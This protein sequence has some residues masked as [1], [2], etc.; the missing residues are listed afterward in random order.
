MVAV[1]KT[2]APSNM[3][4]L[5]GGAAT[6]E[7]INSEV[8]GLWQYVQVPLSN[9]AGTANAITADCD[10]ALDANKK[11]QKFSLTPIAANTG[12]GTLSVNTK[13]A[14]ALKNR[15][16]SVLVA[17]R[18][19]IGRT[20][21]I[22]NDGVA[23]RLMNDAPAVAGGNYRSMFAYQLA[24]GTDGQGLP[25]GWSKYPL[26]T[27]VMNEIPGLTFDGALNQLTLS[28]KTYEF[29][30]EVFSY[31][32]RSSMVLW[33]VTDNSAVLTGVRSS[34]YSNT[35]RTRCVGKF[36]LAATKVFELRVFRAS[37]TGVAGL[38]LNVNTSSP[39]L[40]EQYGFLDLRS[41]S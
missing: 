2:P 30:A 11:G 33:N 31:A 9:V 20:E 18:L 39:A 10:V 36:T 34:S 1:R 24:V 21:I 23:F 28:A 3:A 40:P 17:N 5:L 15:D 25:I 38:G 22:E 14:L 8:Q 13:P 27:L 26:N 32:S 16:G 41:S 35:E 29:D 6:L 19:S 4:G 37:N 7:A 12:A